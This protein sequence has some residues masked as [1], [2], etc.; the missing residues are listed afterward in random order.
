LKG[1]ILK[2]YYTIAI[3]WERGDR[4]SP[5]FGDYDYECIIDER[6]DMMYSYDLKPS[7]VKIIKTDGTMPAIEQAIEKINSALKGAI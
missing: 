7:Q 6:E 4:F 2:T 5:E 1:F 3:Q